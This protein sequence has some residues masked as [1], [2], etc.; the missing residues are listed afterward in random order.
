MK[1]VLI[2]CEYSGIVREALNFVK[3][4]MDAPIKHICV[5]NPIGAI[6]TAIR[7]PNQIIQPW[8][9]GH[10][11]S[12]TTGLWLKNLPCL[13]PTKIIEPRIVNGKKRWGNQTDSGQNKLSPSCD[14]WKDRARTYQGW[15]DAMASQW[16]QERM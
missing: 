4:L 9:F 13:S 10:D 14:R 7:K 12:K 8:Q 2:A 16:P 15:A 11:A 6:N 1:S 3:L 5:E